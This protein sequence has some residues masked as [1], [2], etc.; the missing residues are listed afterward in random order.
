MRLYYFLF[1]LS[2]ST[3]AQQL[4]PDPSLVKS[5]YFGG[6]SYY[7]D[8]NQSQRLKDFID[9]FDNIEGYTITIHSHTDDIGS[10]EYNQRLSEMRSYMAQKELIEFNVPKELITIQDFGE[11]NPI[12]D[13]STLKGRLMNR[14]VDIIL[15]PREV[16]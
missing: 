8:I 13:N 16:F 14:R 12:Y 2:Y 5:I 10:P 6:G 1:F 15:W 7:I 3:F 11:F 4:A 9:G